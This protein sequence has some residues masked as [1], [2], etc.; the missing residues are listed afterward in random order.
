MRSKSLGLYLFAL[1]TANFP[2]YIWSSVDLKRHEACE[3]AEASR[4][5]MILL[6]GWSSYFHTNITSLNFLQGFS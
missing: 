1:S 2:S 5:G 6:P 4:E 3:G